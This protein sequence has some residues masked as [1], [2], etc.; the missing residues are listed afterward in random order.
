[1]N[2]G[3][4]FSKPSI[5]EGGS[6]GRR[7]TRTTKPNN[8]T[9]ESGTSPRNAGANSGGKKTSAKKTNNGSGSS[10]PSKSS[11]T[12]KA[13]GARSQT[14]NGKGKSSPGPNNSAPKAS[15]NDQ[16]L[17]GA[18]EENKKDQA[19][20]EG[21]SEQEG[22]EKQPAE[23]S[24]DKSLKGLAKTASANATG[25]DYSDKGLKDQLE[26]Q[27]ADVAMDATPGLSQ[28]NSARRKLKDFNKAKKNIGFKDDG[29][30]DKAEDVMDGAVDKGI[31]G[32]KV[33]AAVGAAGSAGYTAMMGLMLMKMFNAL[34]GVVMAGL[35]KIA[36]VFSAIFSGM[37][38][39]FSGVLGVAG[40]IGNAIAAGV[41]A[42]AVLGTSILG[43]GAAQELSRKDDSFIDCVP[44]QTSVSKAS[45][46]YLE[47]GEIEAVRR[48]NAVKL[49]SV[50]S[51]LGGSKEQTAA[52]LGN[53]DKESSLDPTAIE[54]IYGEPFAIG[55]RKQSAIAND[56]NVELIDSDYASRFPAINHVGIGLAQWTNDRNRLLID[57]ADEQGVNWYDFDTQVRFMLDGDQSYRQ[58]QLTDFLNADPDNVFS[59]TERFMNTWIGLSSPNAS[60]GDRQTSA[61]DYLFILE[62]ATTDSD[63]ADS[64][65]SGINVNR[66]AGN[67]AAGA[68]HQDDGCGNPIKSHYA[69]SAVDGTGEVPSGL[70]LTPWSRET[71]PS[72][73]VEFSKDPEDAGLSWGSSSGWANGIIADQCAAL[74]H[75]YFMRLYPD[76]NQNGRP[77]DRPFGDGKDIAELW[78]KHYGEQVVSY[79]SA[80][81][82]FSDATTSEY[83]HAGIVQHVFANGDILINEQNIRGVSGRNGGLS[84]SWSWRVIKKDRYE[85]QK[86]EFFKPA[87]AEPQWKTTKL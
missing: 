60:L 73:L 62:R 79:P 71:L 20:K 83:G 35:G 54:T 68:Y 26:H 22:K 28:F 78:A 34:K 67:S 69:N 24:N 8:P 47:A 13:Q 82:V 25:V 46:E 56:F 51:E 16:K 57:Y 43:F 58:D 86:W 41:T 80:G 18:D 9:G 42:I 38:S 6:I 5:G 53:L 87:D 48:D 72:S 10:N 30:T 11:N 84:Y 27:A 31:K 4:Q 40:A 33:T 70:T 36:G 63:Y 65:L 49:W 15:D 50:Y 39:F 37:G 52:V 66:A 64:I 32:A 7:S 17:K 59:E 61:T 23:G 81:A 74:A 1:M 45:Q 29:I 3:Q 85:Q 44:A 21:K 75:S 55:T 19:N 77:T 2:G 76:W 14:P 12:P